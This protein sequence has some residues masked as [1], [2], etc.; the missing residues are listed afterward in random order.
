MQKSRRELPRLFV[1]E[2]RCGRGDICGYRA[3]AYIN[4]G[5]LLS[6]VCTLMMHIKL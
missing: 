6:I 5:F 3:C 2:Q 1:N 4:R